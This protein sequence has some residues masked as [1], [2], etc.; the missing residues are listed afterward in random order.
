MFHECLQVA[1]WR[2]GVQSSVVGG[3]YCLT[4][5]QLFT[6]IK[7]PSYF[8]SYCSIFWVKVTPP[9]QWRTMNKIFFVSI[10]TTVTVG[11]ERESQ[12]VH[13]L[14]LAKGENCAEL[15]NTSIINPNTERYELWYGKQLMC[16]QGL[17]ESFPLLFCSSDNNWRKFSTMLTSIA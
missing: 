6:Y 2:V 7:A 9:S 14:Q 1:R 8:S 17:V 10:I 4:S 16:I 3:R 11:I 5:A 13:I 15:R 12:P